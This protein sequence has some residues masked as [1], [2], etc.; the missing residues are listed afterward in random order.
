MYIPVETTFSTSIRSHK[1]PKTIRFFGPSYIL[2]HLQCYCDVVWL[3]GWWVALYADCLQVSSEYLQ[4]ICNKLFSSRVC[5]TA[6][7]SRPGTAGRL[8]RQS[9]VSQ[10]SWVQSAVHVFTGHV[11]CTLAVE[12]SFGNGVHTSTSTGS[13]LGHQVPVQGSVLAYKYCCHKYND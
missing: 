11:A 4:T 12:V 8:L 6:D 9:V 7:F 3:L 13:I 1:L 2:C 10:P 5:E